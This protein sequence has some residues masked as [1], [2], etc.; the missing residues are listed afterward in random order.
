MEDQVRRVEDQDAARDLRRLRWIGVVLPVAFVWLFELVRFNVFDSLYSPGEAHLLSAMIMGGGVIVFALAMTFFLDR[1]QRQL[2]GQ[3]TDLTA[4]HAVSTAV[5]GELS[6]PESLD[7]AL[8]RMAV[9]TGALAGLIRASSGADTN[10][11]RS[12]RRR[13]GSARP[14]KVGERDDVA[15]AL[16][17]RYPRQL[18]PGLAWL[19][20]LLQE[21]LGPVPDEATFT[22]FEALDAT[23]LD[24]PLP[25]GGRTLGL[26]RL[27]FH[28]SLR[29]D[30]SAHALADI[31]G[32]IGTA[33]QVGRLV[34]DLQRR[35]R[36]REALYE[37]ALRLTAPADLSAVLDTITGH[38]R[39]LLDA[40]RVVIC[41]AQPRSPTF[42][43][44]GWTDRLARSDDGSIRVFPHPP[45][46]TEHNH[47]NAACPVQTQVPGAAW[48]SR[49]LRGPDGLLG[50]LCVVR[51]SGDPLG[52]PEQMLLAALADMAAI[53]VHTARLRESEQEWLIVSERDR[54]ARELHD[55]LAQVLGIIHMRIRGVE[56]R[57]QTSGVKG[58]ADELSEIADVADEAYRDVREAILGLRETISADGGLEATLREYLTK[59]SRQ[60]GIQAILV[61][62]TPGAG[63]LPPSAEVQLLRVIQE[64]LANVRKHARATRATV[65]F[66]RVAGAVRI[67]V[68][69]DGVGFDPA[70]LRTSLDGGFGMSTMR[71]RVE[72]VGGSLAVDAAPGR[73]TRIEV[74]MR[75]D[76]M[77][78]GPTLPGAGAVN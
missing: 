68:E 74:R 4:T 22:A 27:V 31:G 48:M 51:V 60:T 18:P 34:E 40:D 33:I 41:L 50:E 76:E 26:L 61:C 11:R 39:D 47:R 62:E 55:S 38:A 71:E 17:I 72:Q 28:P 42:R 7:Q 46:D 77:R 37:V 24:L 43:V 36:E 10:H 14:R 6:L 25:A 52:E 75:T 20:G 3:N 56:S 57:L 49:P 1:A 30:L 29:P 16:E 78:I 45:M 70:A 13:A 53:A 19:D 67:V 63:R 15:P 59:Y 21:P 5:R 23:V 32:E 54:I 35:E 9:Q 64:A 73:G 12:T 69:D 58:V 44:G 2:V 65:R 8:T 66:E